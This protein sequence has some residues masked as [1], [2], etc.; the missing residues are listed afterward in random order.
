MNPKDE[1]H[2]KNF[3]R[4][5]LWL[6]R[7][8]RRLKRMQPGEAHDRKAAEIMDRCEQLRKDIQGWSNT[9][10]ASDKIS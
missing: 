9:S 4:A 1:E 10:E 6:V 5:A 8:S 3:T 7:E 2:E